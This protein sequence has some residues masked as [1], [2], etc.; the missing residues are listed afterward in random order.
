VA[1]IT[2]V[3]EGL[4]ENFFGI[5]LPKG[6]PAGIRAAAFRMRELAQY[7]DEVHQHVETSVGAVTK[8]SSG[9]TID[10][11]ST[12]STDARAD[13]NGVSTLSRALADGLDEY[14]QQVEQARERV[15]VIIEQIATTITVGILF[16]FISDGI[17]DLLAVPR[18][19]AGIAAITGEL[20]AFGEAVATV[21]SRLFAYYLDAQ[22]WA[23]ADRGSQALVA[24]ANGLP[25]GSLDQQLA[26][27]QQSADGRVFYDATN[28]AVTASMGGLRTAA[29]GLPGPLGKVAARVLPEN[30][31]RNLATRALARFTASSL[32]YTPVVNFDQGKSTLLPTGAE[33]EQKAL[34]HMVGRVLVDQIRRGRGG[35]R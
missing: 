4:I 7:V 12:A 5:E 17:G 33:L 20:S 28:D 35:S 14:A 34:T 11:F 6:D 21:A 2:D 30:P 29:S 25:V 27:G 10:A 8:P 31:Q 13:L 9:Q 16:G 1:D 15:K 22:A 26:A 19:L 24:A 23:L 32:A 18:V 3:V